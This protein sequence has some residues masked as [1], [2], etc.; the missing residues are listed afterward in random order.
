[1]WPVC[2]PIFD[3]RDDGRAVRKPRI[4]V[5]CGGIRGSSPCSRQSSILLMLSPK[6]SFA[7]V[8]VAQCGAWVA[9]EVRDKIDMGSQLI[10]TS[11]MQ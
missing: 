1:M 10:P 6:L 11:W 5:P 2:K 4:H 3:L 7:T 9:G 8:N